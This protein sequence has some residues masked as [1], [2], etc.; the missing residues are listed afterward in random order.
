MEANNNIS[1]RRTVSPGFMTTET[2]R[3]VISFYDL[4]DIADISLRAK[5]SHCRSYLSYQTSH[6]L[7]HYSP[8]AWDFGINL[9]CFEC[10]TS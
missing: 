2:L 3:G 9:R 1:I 5:S 6:S 10:T 7:S 8:T 4:S